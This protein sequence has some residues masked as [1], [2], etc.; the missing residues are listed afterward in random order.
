MSRA[1]AVPCRLCRPGGG[2]FARGRICLDL[3]AGRRRA[4]AVPLDRELTI[5]CGAALGNLGAAAR[6]FGRTLEVDAFPEGSNPD[7]L[8]PIRLAATGM[9]VQSSGLERTLEQCF[10]SSSKPPDPHIDEAPRL[11]EWGVLA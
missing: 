9:F 3:L 11:G 4:L 1:T 10:D 6:Y 5:S 8:A 2:C 7:R